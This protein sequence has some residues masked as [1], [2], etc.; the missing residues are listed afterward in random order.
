MFKA[1]IFD[2]DDTLIDFMERKKVLI[3]ASVN[4][5]IDA[6]LKED[7]EK[8]I[9]E[10]ERFY[11]N[12]GIEDQK[13]FE[14]FLLKKYGDVDYRVL[15]HA[16]IAYRRANAPLMKVYPHVMET[17]KRLRVKGVKLALLSDAPRLGAY[18]RLVEVGIDTSK[19]YLELTKR[20]IEML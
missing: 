2:L 5:M 6:G 11:W 9:A 19:E 7:K 16:I 13:I 15:A 8:L 14:K 1:V 12:T 3:R 20:R 4:A 10:F 17:L 18:T